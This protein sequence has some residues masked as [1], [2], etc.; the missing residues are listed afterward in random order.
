MFGRRRGGAVRSL[1]D[2]YSL[3]QPQIEKYVLVLS[4]CCLFRPGLKEY[5]KNKS[6][7]YAYGH[8]VWV[9]QHIEKVVIKIFSLTSSQAG[10]RQPMKKCMASVSGALACRILI[11]YWWVYVYCV[12][13]N[14]AGSICLTNFKLINI[15][16]V[17]NSFCPKKW[18]GIF[19]KFFFGTFKDMQSKI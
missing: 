19:L 16:F 6:S 9:C 3:I 17:V 13:V 10:T 4:T 8:N 5:V 12:I 15:K 7:Y 18:I 11:K 14:Q 2:I 1:T